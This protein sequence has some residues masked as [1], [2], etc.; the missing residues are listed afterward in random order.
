MNEVAVIL[1]MKIMI[2]ITSCSFIFVTI[3]ITKERYQSQKLYKLVLMSVK[4][5][6]QY[7]KGEDGYTKLELVKD[8]V[9]GK[10]DVDEEDLNILI[11]SVIYDLKR[12]NT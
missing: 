12:I 5:A 11:E 1:I 2:L 8:F 3:N 6:E 9:M 10:V 7:L 4:G